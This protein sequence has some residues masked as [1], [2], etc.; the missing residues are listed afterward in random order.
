M[1]KHGDIWRS[2]CGLMELRC[3]PGQ[4]VLA[5]VDADHCITDPPYSERTE[6][7]VRSGST[8]QDQRNQLGMGYEPIN[9][10]WCNLFTRV[11][12]DRCSGWLLVCGDHITW[13]WHERAARDIGRYV[14]PPVVLVKKGAAPRM[15]ADG[16]ASHCEYMAVSRPSRSSF[17]GTWPAIPGWYQ[18][19]TVR[20]GHGHHGVRGAKSLEVMRRIVSDYSRPGDLIV[21]PCAGGGTTLL[22]AAMEGRRAIGAEIDP[23]TYAKAVKRLSSGYTPSMFTERREKP[24]QDSLL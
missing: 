11:W 14:F 6:K 19:Q 22:A 5:D 4:V 1:A 23:E 16:P 21:D 17:V 10:A 2:P 13:S 8:M 3:G 9:E 20:H 24:K 12:A 7:G 18:M 15:C